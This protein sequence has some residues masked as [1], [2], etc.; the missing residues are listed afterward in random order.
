MI[1]D[2]GYGFIAADDGRDY[3]FHVNALEAGLEFDELQPD[4]AVSFEVKSGPVRGRAGAAAS[5]RRD[6]GRRRLTCPRAG[7]GESDA[8]AAPPD[9]PIAAE[10]DDDG[11]SLAPSPRRRGWRRRAASAKRPGPEASA[12]CGS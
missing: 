9:H 5:V 1:R 10:A 3:F 4:L 2:R 8:E 7:G 6:S 12:P 11:R